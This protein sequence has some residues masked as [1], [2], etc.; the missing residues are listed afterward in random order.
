M[1]RIHQETNRTELEQLVAKFIGQGGKVRQIA[2]RRGRR[3]KPPD[4][5]RMKRALPRGCATGGYTP[6]GDADNSPH[7]PR[8]CG[9]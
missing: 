1:R 4:L 6:S 5:T 9:I 8:W 2:E 3:L 7:R